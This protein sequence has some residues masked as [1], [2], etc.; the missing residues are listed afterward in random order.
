MKIAGKKIPKGTVLLFLSFTAVSLCLLLIVSAARA[1]RTNNMSKNNMYTG[2][3]KN[4]SVYNAEGGGFWEDIILSLSAKYNDFAIYMPMQDSEIVVRG[5][6][7]KGSVEVPPMIEGEYFDFNTSWSDTPMVVLGKECQEKIAERN[8]KKYYDYGGLEFEVLGVMGTKE[9]S[10]LNHM[11]LLDFRS[12]VRM[13]EV[14]TSYVLDTKKESDL[15]KIGQDLS[16]LFR[17]PAEVMILLDEGDGL[18]PI[19]R[20]LSSGRIM[21]A[22]YVMI[23][24]S[25]SL[26]TI[27]VTSIWLRFRRP[28]L[29]AWQICGYEERMK[30][31]ETAKRYYMAAGFGFVVGLLLMALFSLVMEDIQM[32]A[33]DIVQAFGVTVGLGTIILFFCYL[34]NK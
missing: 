3:Q 33:I 29:F 22:L 10:R 16:G 6:C 12:A 5:I 1:E 23:L 30:G 13:E 32:K 27:L 11:M 21:D 26:S 15:I 14:N 20:L 24:I 25:F 18:S 8:G 9:D 7:V 34:S 17:L 31:L 19:A 2:H 28:L 4:F